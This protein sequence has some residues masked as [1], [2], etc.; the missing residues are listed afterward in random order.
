MLFVRMFIV[1]A[2]NLNAVCQN[3]HLLAK[4]LNAVC[5]NV[6]LLANNLNAVCQNV[7]TY[8]IKYLVLHSTCI[9]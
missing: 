1:L 5:Q 6:H 7:Q 4:N 9:L 2:K 8:I 3:V